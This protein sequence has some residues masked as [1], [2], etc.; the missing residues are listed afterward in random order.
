MSTLVSPT[1]NF[2]IH[3]PKKDAPIPK[4]IKTRETP[5]KKKKACCNK[6]LLIF[7]VASPC[8]SFTLIPVIYDKYAR[9]IGNTHGDKND[10]APAPNDNNT[11]TNNIV[12]AL[13]APKTIPS[14]PS[15]NLISTFHYNKRM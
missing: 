12:S 8:N 9:N 15:I 13:I 4:L 14:S 2:C 1:K 10:K 11:P 6:V 7:F 5:S 3:C